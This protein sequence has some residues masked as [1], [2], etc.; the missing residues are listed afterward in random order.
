MIDL[1]K[2]QDFPSSTR[3]TDVIANVA[4]ESTWLQ[5]CCDVHLNESIHDAKLPTMNAR[6]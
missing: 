4:L 1:H 3:M 5:S 2:R 6:R